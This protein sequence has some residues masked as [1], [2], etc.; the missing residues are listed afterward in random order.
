[1]N[2]NSLLNLTV[3]D[4]NRAAQIKEQIDRLNGELA[5]ILGGEIAVPF[6]KGPGRPAGKR[7]GMS[8]AGRM[9]VAAAQRARWAKINAAKGSTPTNDQ[10]PKKRKM[11]A[12]G[13]KAI[14]A[15][16]RARWAK[17]KAANKPF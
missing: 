3:K 9:A 13:R 2:T 8:E 10:A 16:A 4:L 12:A 5:S 11:S 7:G 6:R 14:A 1:M 17:V 15:G